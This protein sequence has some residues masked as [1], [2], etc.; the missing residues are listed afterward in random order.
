M[1]TILGDVPQTDFMLQQPHDN[2]FAKLKERKQLSPRSTANAKQITKQFAGNENETKI[3]LQW[4][5]FENI[6]FERPASSPL[7]DG[8]NIY[9]NE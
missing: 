9:A 5:G 1:V 3:L 7:R 8:F 4:P 6:T 2:P